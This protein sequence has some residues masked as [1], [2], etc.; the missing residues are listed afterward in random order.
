MFEIHQKKNLPEKKTAYGPERLLIICIS[1]DKYRA[2][3]FTRHPTTLFAMPEI[4]IKESHMLSYVKISTS[5]DVKQLAENI[6][7]PFT[8]ISE[9]MSNLDTGIGVEG[10]RTSPL[11]TFTKNRPKQKTLSQKVRRRQEAEA[12]FCGQI[13][14]QM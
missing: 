11:N 14:V 12:E 4:C 2:Y 13:C 3:C 7:V 10:T 1:P 8:L 9:M 6:L 5:C